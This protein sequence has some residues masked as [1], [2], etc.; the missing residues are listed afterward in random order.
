MKQNS[1]LKRAVLPLVLVSVGMLA[2]CGDDNK[3]NNNVDN[4]TF[5]QKGVIQGT[6][7]D[8]TTGARIGDTSLSVTLVDGVH[9]LNPNMLK[10]NPSSDS[11][12]FAGDYAFENVAITLNGANKTYRIVATA[13]GYQNF[14]GYVTTNGTFTVNPNNTVDSVYGMIG[15]IYMFP[16]GSTAPDLTVNVVAS[17]DPV[18][19]ATVQLQPQIGGNNSTT[20]TTNTIGAS[21]GTM[22]ALTG[23]TDASGN[24]TFAGTS[25]VLGGQYQVVVLPSSSSG[26]NYDLAVGNTYQIGVN[27]P[28]IAQVA[29][30]TSQTNDAVGEGLYIVSASNDD[31]TD[32]TASG[33]LSLTFNRAIEI[34]DEDAFT[35]ILT[36][37]TTAALDST[38]A[39]SGV[40]ASVSTDGLVLTLAPNFSTAVVPYTAA[41][42]TSGDGTADIA[43]SITYSGGLIKLAGDDESS[44]VNPFTL[45][46]LDGNVTSPTVQI[47]D[48]QND[49]VL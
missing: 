12:V 37:A 29:L 13:T 26:V 30:T 10:N 7:F 8:A 22:A 4:N 28:E 38:T 17:S 3:T 2:G 25:L 40:T 43:L 42:G 32:I 31:P 18:E 35:A 47:T 44:T 11:P 49:T 15:N 20:G 45:T 41:T 9:Y 24:V 6:V 46:E 23:T 21:S 5:Q 16:L 34:V 36:N 19:G 27:S 1:A 39:S 48:A 33:Q 14:E